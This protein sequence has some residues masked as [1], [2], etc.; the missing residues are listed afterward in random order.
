MRLTEGKTEKNLSLAQRCDNEKRHR[1]RAVPF[2]SR[3]W[4][5][6]QPSAFTRDA[7]RDILRDAVFL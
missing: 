2:D 7:K 6:C 1:A 3:G 5:K 4:P